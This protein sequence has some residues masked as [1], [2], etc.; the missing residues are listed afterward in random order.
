MHKK[1][2]KKH[3]IYCG[4]D[5]KDLEGYRIV[6]V[7]SNEL[8]LN[9][10]VKLMNDSGHIVKIFFDNLC[11]DGDTLFYTEWQS[12]QHS[13]TNKKEAATQTPTHKKRATAPMMV[14]R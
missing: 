10:R 12:R 5:F 3:A 9:V 4:Q 1:K 7:K 8:D 13:T 14:T 6:E 2:I 11:F